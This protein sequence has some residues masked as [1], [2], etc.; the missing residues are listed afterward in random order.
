MNMVSGGDWAFITAMIAGGSIAFPVLAPVALGSIVVLGVSKLRELRRRRT[1]AGVSLPIV[2]APPGARTLIGRARKLRGTIASLDGTPVFLEQAIIHDRSGAV[3]LR[4]SAA[5][6]FLLDREGE[7]PVLVAGPA[8]IVMPGLFGTSPV[9]APVK[10]GDERLRK[11]GVPGDLV[12]AGQL[13]VSSVTDDEQV[14]SVTGVVEEETLAELAFGRDGG[15][16]PVMRGR[17][18]APLIV[19]DPRFAG[20]AIEPRQLSPR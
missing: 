15:Q 19:D 4:R 8:R 6:P 11:M 18:G 7:G 17:A 13:S 20:V 14:I 9:R 12:I 16:I 1:I 5:V 3:L 2:H 10:R